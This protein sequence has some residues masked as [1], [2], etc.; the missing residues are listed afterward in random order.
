MKC[1]FGSVV[2][3]SG[4]PLLSFFSAS[5]LSLLFPSMVLPLVSPKQ[6][7]TILLPL[8]IPAILLLGQEAYRSQMSEK[9][10]L[11]FVSLD[12]MPRCPIGKI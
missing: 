12:L 10:K 4:L 7:F 6:G 1:D 3:A 11:L 9:M 5:F 2:T 8:V